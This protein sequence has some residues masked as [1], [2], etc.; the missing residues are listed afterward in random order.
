MIKIKN[1]YLNDQN[2]FKLF[3]KIIKGF[4]IKKKKFYKIKSIINYCNTIKITKIIL[5]IYLK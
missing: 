1:Y 2:N 5:I 4:S 3:K